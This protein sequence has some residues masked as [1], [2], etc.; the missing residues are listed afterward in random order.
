MKSLF[1]SAPQRASFDPHP[2][3]EKRWRPSVTAS[4]VAGFVGS[5]PIFPARHARRVSYCSGR[6]SSRRARFP[7]VQPFRGSVAGPRGPFGVRP[8]PGSCAASRL[9]WPCGAQ[10]RGACTAVVT[11][12]SLTRGHCRRALLS[13]DSSA[14]QRDWRETPE[15]VP[16]SA[17]KA[18][19][20]LL[21]FVP[22]RG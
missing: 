8:P 19:L 13:I 7:A 22:R 14:G 15:E 3:R 4:G 17:C 18:V 9:D 2:G 12:P 16:K 10:A 11:R 5:S 6:R 20:G 21:C 1:P